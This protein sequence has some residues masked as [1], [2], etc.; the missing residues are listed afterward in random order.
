METRKKEADE[1]Q[2]RKSKREKKQLLRGGMIIERKREAVVAIFEKPDPSLEND[3][4]CYAM[5][6]LHK[7]FRD[8]K[9]LITEGRKPSEEMQQLFP[10]FSKETQQEILL[11][12]ENF[13][14]STRAAKIRGRKKTKR[15]SRICNYRVPA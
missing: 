15:T 14:R 6:F 3:A 11:F 9:Q 12:M 5:L 8:E 4:F 13:E 7:P 1:E 10:T 2:Q